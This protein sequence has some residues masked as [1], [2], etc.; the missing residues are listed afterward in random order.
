M[1]QTQAGNAIFTPNPKGAL[2]MQTTY[3]ISYKGNRKTGGDVP[4]TQAKAHGQS[5][6]L[7]MQGNLVRAGFNFV[8]WNTSSNGLGCDYR[9]GAGYSSDEPLTLYAKWVNWI[10]DGTTLI[11]PDGNIYN[12]VVIGGQT[13]MKENLKTTKYNDGSAIPGPYYA[14]TAWGPL[15]TP[16]YCFYQDNPSNLNTYGALY[17]WH[18]ANHPKIAPGGWHVPD[19]T[20]WNTLINYLGGTEVAG[21]KLK[22]AGT[23]HWAYDPNT[24]VNSSGFTA[25]PG[26]YRGNGGG[27]TSFG[28]FKNIGMSGRWWSLKD[29]TPEVA[30]VYM[31]NGYADNFYENHDIKM[32]GFSI[33]LIKD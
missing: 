17:N 11:D 3:S 33:R 28:D 26:G 2:N 19:T 21:R 12:T 22:A 15:N 4:P 1:E 31:L 24:G 30:S 25:L 13:W 29:V 16:A 20:E 23:A 10:V 18:A 9:A 7:A 32:S 5:I 27:N 8:G 14:D 6:N